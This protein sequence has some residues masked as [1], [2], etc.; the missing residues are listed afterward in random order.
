MNKNK[1]RA[2]RAIRK[3][4]RRNMELFA[5]VSA[6]DL[7][8]LGEAMVQVATQLGQHFTRAIEETRKSF[9]EFA[10]SYRECLDQNYRMTHMALTTGKETE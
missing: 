9:E 4:R 6:I 7:D 5:A 10:A 3:Q 2:G 1:R 8:A